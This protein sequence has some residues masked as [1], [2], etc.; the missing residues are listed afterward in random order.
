MMI[1]DISTT[2]ELKVKKPTLFTETCKSVM[3]QNENRY[4]IKIQMY[5]KVFMHQMH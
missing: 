4:Q 3:F 2:T 1:F 5:I